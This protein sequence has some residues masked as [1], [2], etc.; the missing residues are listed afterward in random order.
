MLYS[1]CKELQREYNMLRTR[2][3]TKY[4]PRFKE[5]EG[6]IELDSDTK[7]QAQAESDQTSARRRSDG[8]S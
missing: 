7:I 4:T 6:D 1:L 5:F 2:E 3:S 8:P